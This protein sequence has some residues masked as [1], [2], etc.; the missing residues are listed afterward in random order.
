MQ[1]RTKHE[2]FKALDKYHQKL[3]KENMDA[4]PE[5]SHF[6][7]TREKF[8]GHF[9]E[10]NTITLLSSRRDAI[11]NFQ[12]PSNKKKSKNFLEC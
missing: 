10:G 8:L 7:L 5:K 11:I 4:A 6:F 3:L 12:S 2:M 1:S 9:I